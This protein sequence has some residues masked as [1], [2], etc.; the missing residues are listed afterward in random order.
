M[1]DKGFIQK[2]KRIGV[3]GIARSGI[4]VA[5]K[6]KKLGL[7]AFLSDA[8][9]AEKFLEMD[10]SEFEGSV[11]FGGHSDKLLEMDLLVVSPG[12]PLNIPILEKARSKSIPLWSEVEFA[13]QLTYPDAKIIAV[14]GTN[15]K[16]TAVSLIYHIL[17]S[18]GFDVILAGN[19]G[20][21]YSSFDIEIKRDFIVLEVSS[22]QLDLVE[23]FRP[24]TAVILNITPDHL[25]RYNTFED[26][27]KSKFNIAKNLET[28][29]N[30]VLSNDLKARYYDRY[31]DESKAAN[32]RIFDELKKDID[33]LSVDDVIGECVD[34]VYKDDSIVILDDEFADYDLVINNVKDLPLKGLHNIQ[35]IMAALLAVKNYVDF[36]EIYDILMS[37]KPL[38]HRLEPVGIHN[39]V[40]YINDSKAT[41]TDSVKYAITAFD[42]PIHLILGGSDKGEDFSVLIDS[43]RGKVKRLYLIGETAK[44]MS[45]I[46]ENI[47]ECE[48]FT[49]FKA[50]VVTAVRNASMGEIVLLSPACASFD[51]F[52]NFEERGKVFKRLVD[53]GVKNKGK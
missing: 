36:D 6:I 7:E 25:D 48:V 40:E 14:T 21:A 53:E 8:R 18:K 46:F 47:F 5:I 38:E 9:P 45:G 51:W 34:A 20:E 24:D 27:V 26:Y 10:L 16:S 39:G 1:R 50:T 31:I 52:K 19:I 41:N 11:E 28:H 13:Y 3:L 37:F 23:A 4:A 22:F 43:M 12:I 44:K 17:K 49:D 30:L 32:V 29:D 15:G 2:Y 42:K 33:I 35:N